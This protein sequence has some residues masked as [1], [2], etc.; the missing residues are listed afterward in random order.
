MAK[1]LKVKDTRGRRGQVTSQKEEKQEVPVIETGFFCEVC[2]YES[3]KRAKCKGFCE[4]CNTFLCKPCI[5]KHN[6]TP[7]LLNHTLLQGARMPRG[8]HDK[9]VKYSDC[10][11][12][13]ERCS[14]CYC[15]H[16]KTLICR[17]CKRD[18]HDNCNVQFVPLLCRTL[19]PADANKFK[20]SIKNTIYTVET[21]R[22]VLEENISKI[23][24]QRKRMI[25]E[26]TE[27]RDN[28]IEKINMGLQKT[29]ESIN[30]FCNEKCGEITD[31]MST[32][33]NTVKDY[34]EALADIDGTKD[35]Y[36]GP[37]VFLRFQA[38]G[39]QTQ[40]RT[41]KLFEQ[42]KT[43]ELNFC[44]VFD[45]SL[46]EE[47]MKSLGGVAE[48]IQDISR[49]DEY[50]CVRF[51]DLS[52]LE[53]EKEDKEKHRDI[54]IIQAAKKT[55]MNARSREDDQICDIW[56]MAV[57]TSGSLLILDNGNE[58][59]RIMSLDNHVQ[60]SLT[61]PAQLNRVAVINDKKAVV[62]TTQMKGMPMYETDHIHILDISNEASISVLRSIRGYCR[63]ICPYKN[64]FIIATD[65]FPSGVKMID[66]SDT[67]LVSIAQ[68]RLIWPK[69]NSTSTFRNPCGIVKQFRGTRS[70]VVVNYMYTIAT[71]D[72][73]TG[74]IINTATLELIDYHTKV[75]VSFLT[76]DDYG[77]VYGFVS[78][79][80]EIRIWSPDLQESKT[81]L[82]ATELR[83]D[84][85]SMI[86]NDETEELYVSYRSSDFID[87]FQLIK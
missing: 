30:A 55:P 5:D 56:G 47:W 24:E 6:K 85:I 49:S 64:Y 80:N 72:A 35:E 11:L 53:S 1:R 62:F 58:S 21:V 51:P 50:P 68:G 31:R 70:T 28:L 14:D 22:S 29:T 76:T 63:G 2:D 16:H 40:L 57:T 8:L 17:Q 4:Q 45:N 69:L 15:F 73:S 65:Y 44:S 79:C 38:I 82:S 23:E 20:E 60:S 86:Y 67:E 75:Y 66:Y 19:G 27:F 9:P 74:D 39:K 71:L 25:Q 34:E 7:G 77:N 78:P 84:P 61:I 52:N 87:R 46:S 37:S 3:D 10:A 59:V 33:S 26:A 36:I 18:Y 81:L 48:D 43:S 13:A 32:L 41:K 12:H 54:S 83:S 42:C